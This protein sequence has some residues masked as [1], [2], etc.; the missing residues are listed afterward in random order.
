LIFI[1][2][3]PQKQPTDVETIGSPAPAHEKARLSAQTGL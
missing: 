3:T 2:T 1:E